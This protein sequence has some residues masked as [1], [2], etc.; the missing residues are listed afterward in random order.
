MLEA[1]LLD[2]ILRHDKFFVAEAHL[3]FG[4]RHIVIVLKVSARRLFVWADL[5]MFLFSLLEGGL[6]RIV[7]LFGA[8]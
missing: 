5:P 1:L 4:G 2:G 3:V 6:I 8:I 7:F